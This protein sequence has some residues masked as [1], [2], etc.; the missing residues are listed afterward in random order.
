MSTLVILFYLAIAL[1]SVV[2][3]F[4][5]KRLSYWS[6]RGIPHDEPSFLTGSMKGVGST[7][8][9]SDAYKKIYSR[10]KGKEQIVGFFNFMSPALMPLDLEIV[11]QI[12][13]KDF[14]SFSDRGLYVNERDDP[15]SGHLVQLDG[16]KWKELRHKLTPTFTSGK[17]K[18]MFPTVIE[19]GNRFGEVLAEKV[20]KEAIVEVTELLGRF[21]T[22]VIGTCAF[23]IECNSLRDPEAKFL[24]MGRE[25]LIGRHSFAVIGFMMAFPNLARFLHMKDNKEE[26]IEFF[27]KIVHENVDYREKNNIHRNDFLNM[28]IEM[29]NKPNPELTMDELAAQSFIFFLAGFE[30]S[31]TTMGFALHELAVNQDIQDKLRAE[32]QE[33]LQN[34]NGEFT[35]DCMVEM[36]YLDQVIDETLRKHSVVPHLIRKATVDYKIPQTGTLV[37]KDTVVV[38]PVD[39]IHHD[40]EIYPNPEKFDPERFTAEAI[41]DRP[42]CAYLPFGDGPRNCIGL[43]F[44]KMQARIGLVSLLRKFKFSV[45][46]KTDVPLKKS[47]KGLLTSALNGIYLKAEKL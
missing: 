16:P 27:M 28:L 1:V 47:S 34:H 41:Q 9:F 6:D 2:Y 22:D 17:M 43:R 23:G 29:K 19:V 20:P 37:E 26:V 11:K 35:Y 14:G 46:D 25:S 18:F 36:K 42:Q 39:A 24:K 3:F 4:I 15:L 10:F 32:I 8:H 38:V 21:T 31:S 5:K 12:L 7:R 33:V 40:S 45:C 44:G 30:T 13:I